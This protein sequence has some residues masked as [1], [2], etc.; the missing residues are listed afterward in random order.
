VAGVAPLAV[1][2]FSPKTSRR[3]SDQPAAKPTYAA[4]TT[5]L[6]AFGAGSIAAMTLFASSMGLIAAGAQHR[7][8]WMRCSE[9]ARL[10][11]SLSARRGWRPES[12]RRAALSP[13]AKAATDDPAMPAD[14]GSRGAADAA[15]AGVAAMAVAATSPGSI[16]SHRP[17]YSGSVPV[18]AHAG[19]I[20]LSRP[21]P[22]R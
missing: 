4:S 12:F 11:P 6:F 3:A 16:A 5:Y 7:A 19:R 8:A 2:L 22:L 17:Y 13:A 14:A 15:Y 10:P 9:P 21:R 1:E 20:L 18:T